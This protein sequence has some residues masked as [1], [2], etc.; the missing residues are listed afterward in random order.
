MT[1]NET[2]EVLK[3]LKATYPEYYRNLSK[4]ETKSMVD[5]WNWAYAETDVKEVLR[6][7]KSFITTDSKGFPPKPGQLNEHLNKLNNINELSEL[8]AWHLISKACRN[9]SYKAKEEFDKLPDILQKLVGSPN[10]LK[11]WSSLPQDE[12]ETVVQSNFM[13]SYKHKS[14][15]AKY[16]NSL[17]KE[18]FQ[19]DSEN[20]D[21]IE[22][23]SEDLKEINRLRKEKC[24]DELK[25]LKDLIKR[26][27]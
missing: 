16:Y 8:Q 1:V 25:L 24:N 9:S 23:G 22:N 17:P 20:F 2:V 4:E 14:E 27:D 19:S 6:A 18:L 3:I 15:Q 5:M 10:Q 13:R 26:E 7:L 11:Y 12:F 21:E